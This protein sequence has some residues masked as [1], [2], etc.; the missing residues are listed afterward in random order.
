MWID[1]NQKN[2]YNLLGS[3]QNANQHK[4]DLFEK[5]VLG[6]ELQLYNGIR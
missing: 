2:L 6:L 1:F 5:S 4:I 3:M